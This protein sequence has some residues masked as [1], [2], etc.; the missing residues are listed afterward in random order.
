MKSSFGIGIN[1]FYF[2]FLT[3]I[4]TITYISVAYCSFG[5]RQFS[6]QTYLCLFNYN[7]LCFLV[8]KLK[9]NM[10]NNIIIPNSM[11]N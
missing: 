3:F 5:I 4:S 6:L 7:A 11:P 2:S 8:N 9:L 1:H 10:A